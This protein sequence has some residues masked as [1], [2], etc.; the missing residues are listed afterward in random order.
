MERER[1][2]ISVSKSSLL[3]AFSRSVVQSLHLKSVCVCLS[4]VLMKRFCVDF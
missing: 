2:K 3:R 4:A 1:D